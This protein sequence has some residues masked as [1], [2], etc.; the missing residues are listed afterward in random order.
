MKKFL[1][2]IL[3]SIVCKQLHAQTKIEKTSTGFQLLRNGKPY[4]VKG[5]GG[6]V[7]FDDMVKIGANSFRTWGIDDAK[8]VLDEAQQRGLTVMLGFWLQ[9]ERHGFDY[10]DA[11]KVKVQLDHFKRMV[12][13]F[14]DH[15]ALL[16]WGIG[17]ELDLEYTNPACWDAVQDIAKYIHKTDPN[18]PTSTVTA[19][20]DSLEVAHIL[21]KCPDIDIY[22]VNTYGDIGNVPNSIGRFGWKGPYM[23]T[24]WGPNGH[25]ESPK[26]VWGVSIEQS[27]SEKREVYE[28]RFKDYILPNKDYCLGSYAF[29]WGAKQEYTETWYGLF[30][31][32][33]LA[34]EPVDAL[35]K[36]FLNTE[37]KFP[38]PTIKEFSINNKV[39]KDNIIIKADEKNEAMISAVIASSQNGSNAKYRWR[40][41]QESTDKKNGGD[42]EDEATEIGGLIKKGSKG[43]QIVFYAPK[44]PGQYR[45][46]VSVTHNNKVAYSNIPFKVIAREA[47]DPQVKFAQFK[48]TDMSSFDQ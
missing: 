5:V 33:N 1:L 38:T 17:N 32:E 8:K 35:E 10:S 45:L 40:I 7:N 11:A 27:S 9:H 42:K 12:D 30:S 28:S 18:H 36:A 41:M 25:W 43:N 37:I 3:V 19:G 16:F 24:E 13:Q 22:C 48:F 47:N 46:F 26:T 23:I 15:P 39:A 4:Y 6:Q 2:I 21:K 20:L 44:A 34:T 29:L 14:K 31:K